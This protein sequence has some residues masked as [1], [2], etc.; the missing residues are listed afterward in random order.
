M[1]DNCYVFFNSNIKVNCIKIDKTI[2]VID[3]EKDELTEIKKTAY[4][5]TAMT[6]NTILWNDF[7][8]TVDS[9]YFDP[10]G[11]VAN[12]TF[13]IYRKTPD[14]K[15]YDY[16]CKI[17]D[18]ATKFT[19]Y[20]ITTDE[21]YHYLAAV[22]V[23]T[24]AGLEYKLY[25][26][27]ADEAQTEL[28]YLYIQWQDWTICDI[29]DSTEDNIYIKSGDVWH[30]KYNMFDDVTMTMNTNVTMWETLGQFGKYSIGQKNFDGGSFSCLIGDID[31]YNEY[32]L[33][34]KTKTDSTT[35]LSYESDEKMKVFRQKRCDY[36][37]KIN[38]TS[39]YGR[40]VE[41]EKAWKTFITNGNLKLLK[42]YKGNSWVVMVQSNPTY[43]VD[44]KSNLLETM[45]SF[46]WQEAL[47]VSKIAIV[48]IL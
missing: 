10:V 34:S 6:S 26:N 47:D 2:S 35:G 8:S 40:Q 44:Y 11:D 5:S 42:D 17:E 46:D 41:K 14:Q 12:T 22:E 13:S 37:E 36:N 7:S 25:Q 4:G 48:E 29:V 21:Y 16:I 33:I 19:D 39:I 15:Y 23:T 31:Y 24:S 38:K 1:A 18:G 28:D 20:N 32:D 9:S 45:I 30:L 43:Q 3:S 27:Y